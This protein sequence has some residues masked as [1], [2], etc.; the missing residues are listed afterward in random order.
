M[1]QLRIRFVRERNLPSFLI[2]W[3]EDILGH[4]VNRIAWSHVGAIT[5]D[6]KYEFGARIHPDGANKPGVQYRPFDYGRFVQQESIILEVTDKEHGL[7]WHFADRLVGRPYSKRTILGFAF[8]CQFVDHE[9]FICS[10]LIPYLYYKAYML[11]PELIAQER[12]MDPEGC[13]YLTLG[14][15]EG[16]H[17]ITLGS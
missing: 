3:H 1:A 15:R 7:F 2:C 17:A 10:A 13:Y 12:H 4:S 16:R 5:D 14:M 6:G 11:P 8:G 9:G